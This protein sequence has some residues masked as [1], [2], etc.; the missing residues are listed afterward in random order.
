MELIYRGEDKKF[1]VRIKDTLTI[2]KETWTLSGTTAGNIILSIDGRS[3]F[4]P[5]NTDIATTLSDFS[6]K[7]K[8]ALEEC[9]II[10]SSTSTT[11][12]FEALSTTRS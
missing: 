8:D 4:V 6:D 2:Q 1:S 3:Y 11:L 5:F 7:F 9:D 12:V 10:L